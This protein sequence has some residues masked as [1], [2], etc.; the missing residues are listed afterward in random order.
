MEIGHLSSTYKRVPTVRSSH[1]S[2][3][4]RYQ[5]VEPAISIS[6]PNSSGLMQSSFHNPK[7]TI[8][9]KRNKEHFGLRQFETVDVVTSRLLERSNLIKL[10]A[11]KQD[12]SQGTSLVSAEIKVP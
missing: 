6:R 3:N 5:S 8:F 11:N 2:L 12:Y 4:A 7:K 9:Q 10:V 1:M